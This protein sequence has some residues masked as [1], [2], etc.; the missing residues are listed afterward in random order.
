MNNH[1]VNEQPAGNQNGAVQH[2]SNA[3]NDG[4]VD[5]P[6]GNQANND[7]DD[8]VAW[9]QYSFYPRMGIF[10]HE[11]WTFDNVTGQLVFNPTGAG[12]Q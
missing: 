12:G 3:N 8:D 7:G 6:A 4:H 9:G 5:Q 11:V 2:V 10:N 1:G